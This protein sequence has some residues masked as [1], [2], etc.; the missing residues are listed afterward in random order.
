VYAE[1]MTESEEEDVRIRDKINQQELYSHANYHLRDSLP[2]LIFSLVSVM[3]MLMTV[4]KKDSALWIKH[5]H[6]LLM[7]MDKDRQ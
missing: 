6:F 1:M 5:P 7:L 3:M 2:S 4:C